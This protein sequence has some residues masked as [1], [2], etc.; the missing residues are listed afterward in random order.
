[1]RM[2][3]TGPDSATV[4]AFP[5]CGAADRRR[6]LRALAALQAALAEQRQAVAAWRA[7]TDELGRALAGL[8]RR[9]GAQA[10]AL[11]RVADEAGHL[12][13]ASRRLE[14]WADAA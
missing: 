6:L 8:E 5:R 11:D 12:G 14:R 3:Q 10:R 9:L 4:L 13:A 7:A 1:M 2:A